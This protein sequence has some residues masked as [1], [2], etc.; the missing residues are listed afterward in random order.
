MDI[1]PHPSATRR[2]APPADWNEAK[3]GACG[4]LEIADLPTP[5]GP[6]MESLWRPDAGDLAALNA[7]AGIALGIRGTVHPVVYLGVTAPLRKDGVAEGFRYSWWAAEGTDPDTY[8]INEATREAVIEAARREY[9]PDATFT[10]IEATQDGDLRSNVFEADDD[11]LFD[12]VWERFSESNSE[13]WS[14]D[15]MEGPGANDELC[16]RLNAAFAGWI[17]ENAADFPTWGF[18]DS[19]NKEVISP[20]PGA[21]RTATGNGE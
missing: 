14:E 3:H 13:R 18:T 6:Y 10:I 9:G 16:K 1:Q 20:A 15:G 8:H 2:F 21:E 5:S 19:R 4:T 17:A 7:G 11:D 12:H